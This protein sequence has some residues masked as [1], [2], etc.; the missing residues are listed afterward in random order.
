MSSLILLQGDLLQG[1]PIDGVEDADER[2]PHAC[3][4]LGGTKQALLPI[5]IQKLCSHFSCQLLFFLLGGFNHLLQRAITY[6]H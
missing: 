3:A 2:G 5:L 6:A 4:G 1:L